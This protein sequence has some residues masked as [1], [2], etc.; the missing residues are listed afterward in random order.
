MDSNLPLKAYEDIDF[1]KSDPCRSV[2]LQLEF[3]KPEVTMQEHKIES[4]IVVFGS[5][6]IPEPEKAREEYEAA[7]RIAEQ[8]PEDPD[9]RLKLR[10]AEY[11]VEQSKYYVLARDF[12]ELVTQS[13]Q[14]DG[15][16]EFVIMT[17]GG[18]GI[19]EAG[20]RG[21][22]DADGRT[23]GLNIS[24]PSEQIENPF[25]SE[26]LCFQFHYFSLRKMHFLKRAKALCVFPGGFGT[27]DELFETI[28]LIQTGKITPIPVVL[29]GEEF[30]RE[31]INW[32]KFSE[33]GLVAP[34]DLEIIRFCRTAAEGWEYIKDFWNQHEKSSPIQK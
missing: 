22:A 4:T 15:R 9:A 12:A 8:Q 26:G 1:L 23:V 14:T 21:A 33:R 24:I 25:I 20:N 17:G 18:G 28:T 27:M 16:K 32:E 29:F 6:R 30:W 3:L 5:S 10:R 11:M 13:S 31:M 2:R 7:L 34:E 19:M